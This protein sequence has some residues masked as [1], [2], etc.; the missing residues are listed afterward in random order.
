[1]KSA[2]RL[3]SLAVSLSVLTAPAIAAPLSSPEPRQL[4]QEIDPLCRQVDPAV[5][6]GLI[7]RLDPSPFSQGII[8]IAPNERLRLDPN[9][10]PPILGPNGNNWLP[11]DFPADGYINNGA[12]GRTNV[13]YCQY[14]GD[15]RVAPRPVPRPVVDPVGRPRSRPPIG[16]SCRRVIEEEGL[17]VRRSPSTDASV[18]GGVG[19]NDNVFITLPVTPIPGDDGRDWIEIASPFRGYISN[20]YGDGVSNLG[21]CP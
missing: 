14:F 11:V 16:T 18:I 19:F 10:E 15:R 3:S 7:V 2:R 4:V 1:M 17:V 5:R 6:E 12:P 21:A 20:G 13:V 8:S 9:Y